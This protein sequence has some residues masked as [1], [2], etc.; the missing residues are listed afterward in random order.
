MVHVLFLCK[1]NRFRSKVA[2]SL[3]NTLAKNS[4]DEAR[5]AGIVSGLPISDDIIRICAEEGCA[6]SN[7]PQG[8]THQLNMWADKIV[9]IEDRISPE[10]FNEEKTNDGKEILQWK[11]EDIA[12]DDHANRR[13]KIGQI[14]AKVEEL[15]NGT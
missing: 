14:K 11:I 13:K 2:E 8:L 10:I 5:S 12:E 15:I 3:F 9:I 6:I 7:P 4:G 1:Y